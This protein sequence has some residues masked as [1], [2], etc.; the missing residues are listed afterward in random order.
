MAAWA[1]K[2][3]RGEENRSSV[4]ARWSKPTLSNL[5]CIR[6]G[7]SC[8]E[9]R[10]NS[11]VHVRKRT[12]SP[13]SPIGTGS[14]PGS[15]EICQPPSD[16]GAVRGAGNSTEEGEGKPLDPDT[17]PVTRGRHRGTD[18]GRSAELRL[19]FAPSPHSSHSGVHSCKSPCFPPTSMLPRLCRR[20]MQWRR[21]PSVRPGL[22]ASGCGERAPTKAPAAQDTRAAEASMVRPPAVAGPTLS[23]RAVSVT[24]VVQ[25]EPA[26]EAGT[27]VLNSFLCVC[28]LWSQRDLS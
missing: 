9:W 4:P 24:T 12:P 11:F 20:K 18:P 28:F 3:G 16:P 7:S 14:H 21:V 1:P 22:R 5:F 13:G 26:G 6:N 15:V 19:L 27:R 10:S 25:E 23:I 8:S 2:G 17:G